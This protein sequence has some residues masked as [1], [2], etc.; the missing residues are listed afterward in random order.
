MSTLVIGGSGFIGRHLVE[1]LI[2]DKADVIVQT[3]NLASARAQLG[4]LAKQTQ[5]I[6]NLDELANPPRNVVCLS[7][8]P[9][10][11]H[12]WTAARKDVLEQS[13][14]VPLIKLGEWL[15]SNDQ[16]CE[17]LL[18][19]SAIGYYGFPADANQVLDEQSPYTDHYTHRL[20]KAVEEQAKELV[21]CFRRVCIMR[22]GVVL[23]KGGGA[24][25]KMLTPAKFYL[26][27]KIGDGQHWV[28]WIHMDDM[29][30]A[31]GYLLSSRKA[32]GPYNLVSPNPA[33]NKELSAAIGAALGKKFQLPVPTISLQLLLGEAA[34][35][36]TRSQKVVP[37]RLIAE[38]FSFRYPNLKT[39]ISQIVSD[40][41]H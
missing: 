2:S 5:L 17:A 8:A 12:R 30:Q 35:L 41:T 18:V 32:S 28:S 4:D 39:A 36:L 10:V 6:E 33:T 7:G 20:C 3:R 13:R 14:L 11:D 27:G 26:N 1:K 37:N 29:I 31:I 21:N 40:Q 23:G 9:I 34:E 25:A 16:K 24:L 38:D 15:N 19:G 22:T